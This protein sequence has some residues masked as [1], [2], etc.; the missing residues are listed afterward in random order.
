MKLLVTRPEPGATATAQRL[1]LA[2]HSPVILSCLTISHLSPRFP[3]QIGALLVTSGQAI[4][5]LPPRLHTVPTFCVGDATAA[6]LRE[7]GFLSVESASGTADDLRRLVSARRLRGLHVLATGSRLGL[8]LLA[9]LRNAGLTA[10][11]RVVYRPRPIRLLPP[12]IK[13]TLEQGGFEG[14]LFYSAETA[15]AFAALHPPGTAALSAYALSPAIAKSLQL[16][17]WRDIRVALAPTE[18]DMMALL[19]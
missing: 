7:A 1:T 9:D 17:P 10:T 13:T 3:E 19:T 11:R 2:G 16:L 18:A 5:A 15:R 12:A 6:K 4:P 14:A 8:Q